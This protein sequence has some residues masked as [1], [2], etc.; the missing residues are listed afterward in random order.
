MPTLTK[1][2]KIN[3]VASNSCGLDKSLII[4][5]ERAELLCLICAL[6]FGLS[7]KKALSDPEANAENKMST[8]MIKR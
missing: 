5:L 4:S 3:I 7:E 6:S 2:L 1:L 8:R